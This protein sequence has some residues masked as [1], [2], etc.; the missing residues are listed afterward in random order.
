MKLIDLEELK[1]NL[2]NWEEWVPAGKSESIYDYFKDKTVAVVG[3][4]ASLFDTEYGKEIDEH[5]IVLRI[6]KPAIFF[7][8]KPFLKSHGSRIDVWAFWDYEFFLQKTNFLDDSPEALIKY[9]ASEDYEMFNLKRSKGASP[10]AETFLWNG[11]DIPGI[12]RHQLVNHHTDDY[13]ERNFSSGLMILMILDKLEAKHIDVYGFDFK[14][15]HTFNQLE[16]WETHLVNKGG[17]RNDSACAHIYSSEEDIALRYI[18]TQD[19]FTLKNFF[20]KDE[21]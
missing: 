15:T 21:L 11:K 13:L 18:F 20:W 8:D 7:N 4:A 10:Q 19:R 2:S 5:D 9:L 1:E 14:R 6:N 16:S 12:R 3:N 17:Y